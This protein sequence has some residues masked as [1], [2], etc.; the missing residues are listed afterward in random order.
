MSV[1]YRA[2]YEQAEAGRHAALFE[3]LEER[4]KLASLGEQPAKQDELR[5]PAHPPARPDGQPS[6]RVTYTKARIA[7]CPGALIPGKTRE[8]CGVLI[9]PSAALCTWHADQERED[10]EHRKRLAEQS[11]GRPR[12]RGPSKEVA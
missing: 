2:K 3:L 11:G 7:R 5:L 10:R 12:E 9:D 6:D 1:D 8:A 4:R